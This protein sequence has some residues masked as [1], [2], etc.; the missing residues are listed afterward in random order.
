ME[1][2]ATAP[3]A[4]SSARLPYLRGIDGLRALAVMAVLLYHGGL[5]VMSGFLG[6]ETFFVLSGFLITALLLVEW[7]QD[8]SIK[9]TTFWLR[10]A[11]RLFPALLLLLLGTSIYLRSLLQLRC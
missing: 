2:S 3:V 9:V 5:S 10:R 11:R 4:I 6:V 1:R 8:G 7:R